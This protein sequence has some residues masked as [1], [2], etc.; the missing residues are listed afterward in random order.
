MLFCI[1]SVR[2]LFR[3]RLRAVLGHAL[4]AGPRVWL[5]LIASYYFY[6]S[7]K[8]LAGPV[9]LR[10]HDRDYLV[11]GMNAADAPTKRRLLL[12]GSL[13]ANLGMLG[14]FQYANFFLGLCNRLDAAGHF[15]RRCRSCR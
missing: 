12:F 15:R 8:S 6:A 9:D 11:P 10:H 13:A 5:L 1:A 7:W 3:A 14:L 4:A 2:G